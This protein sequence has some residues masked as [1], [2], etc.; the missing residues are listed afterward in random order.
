MKY[1]FIIDKEAC[2]YDWIQSF[3]SWRSHFSEKENTLFLREHK[4][5]NIKEKE[6]L[7]KLED[8]LSGSNGSLRLWNRYENKFMW[9]IKEKILWKNVRLV[10]EDKFNKIWEERLPQLQEWKTI[11]ENYNFLVIENHLHASALFFNSSLPNNVR[12]KLLFSSD[13]GLP[14]GA[15]LPQKFKNVVLLN[16]AGC[17]F[18]ELDRAIGVLIHET[19]H[20]T[21]WDSKQMDYILQD[22]F[23]NIILPKKI[24]IGPWKWKNLI[25][26]SLIG[27]VASRRLNN[28][29]GRVISGVNNEKV[30][31]DSVDIEKIFPDAN[32]QFGL[33][34]RKLSF[35]VEEEIS[36]YINKNRKFDKYLSDN[37]MQCWIDYLSNP[38]HD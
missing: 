31:K 28:Y 7:K 30:I 13:D 11:L 6:T 25:H 18:N 35:L 37:I 4:E 32:D 14:G 27:S 9:S 16:V 15:S 20:L 26:E 19:M 36:S 5:L 1:K 21:I 23:R 8:F 10:F 24:K 12:V 33:L 2:F 3:I 38:K 29:F 17:N 22:S 34:A